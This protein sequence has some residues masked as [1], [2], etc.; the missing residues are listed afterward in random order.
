MLK[1]D[2]LIPILHAKKESR[3]GGR[4]RPTPVARKKAEVSHA[5]RIYF[6]V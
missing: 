4:E 6:H 2:S 1:E 5:R 3:G